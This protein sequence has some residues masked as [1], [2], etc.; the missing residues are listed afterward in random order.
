MV[1]GAS[2][3]DVATDVLVETLLLWGVG[4]L[5]VREE[6]GSSDGSSS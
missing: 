6:L 3:D 1:G 4:F 2:L 5:V